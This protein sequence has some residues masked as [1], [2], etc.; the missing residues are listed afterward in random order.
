VQVRA[1]IWRVPRSAVPR[2]RRAQ[3]LWLFEQWEAV[4]AFVVAARGDK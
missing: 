3:V 2:E 4:N 1:K